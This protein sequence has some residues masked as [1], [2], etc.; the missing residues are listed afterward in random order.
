[1]SNTPGRRKER[2]QGCRNDLRTVLSLATDPDPSPNIVRQSAVHFRRLL[3]DGELTFTASAV[4][5][6]VRLV[7]PPSMPSGDSLRST[8]TTYLQWSPARLGDIEVGFLSN[9]SPQ[10]LPPETDPFLLDSPVNL[11]AFLNQRV[12]EFFGATARRRDFIQYAANVMGGAHFGERIRP[13][14]EVVDRIRKA[15][16]IEITDGNLVIKFEGP[17]V[18][19]RPSDIHFLGPHYNPVH[20]E[21]LATA[22][23]I[24]SSPFTTELLD[25]IANLEE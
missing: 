2:V 18:L 9:G 15:V 16:G 11:D 1:M 4:G 3:I 25:A 7:V 10:A 21:L 23:L 5:M 8:G 13:H 20:L 12:A 14:L 22:R 6:R 24:A 19:N 17:A